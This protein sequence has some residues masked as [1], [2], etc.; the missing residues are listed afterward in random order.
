M[1]LVF[2]TGVACRSRERMG[3]EAFWKLSSVSQ[4]PRITWQVS[5]VKQALSSSFMPT[6][7]KQNVLKNMDSFASSPQTTE[8]L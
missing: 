2:F 5:G 6:G 7:M 3:V 1:S 4:A 8:G